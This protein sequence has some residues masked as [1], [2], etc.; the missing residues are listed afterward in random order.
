MFFYLIIFSQILKLVTDITCGV[1]YE[2]ALFS[3]S[4][5]KDDKLIWVIM[6]LVAINMLSRYVTR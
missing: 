6:S 1:W 2:L 4:Q 5:R 3:M